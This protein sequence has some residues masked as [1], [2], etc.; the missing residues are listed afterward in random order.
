[1][2]NLQYVTIFCVK[3]HTF[4]STA[5]IFRGIRLD[6]P[7]HW[8]RLRDNLTSRFSRIES[9]INQNGINIKMKEKK[10][11]RAWQSGPLLSNQFFLGCDWNGLIT[12]NTGPF[13]GWFLAG[14][15]LSENKY[16]SIITGGQRK[17][18]R[19]KGAGK[20][21]KQKMQEKKKWNEENSP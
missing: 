6:K 15:L 21:W 13:S 18:Q 12:E 14:A 16:G 9:Q 8:L 5:E 11:S 7:I 20:R 10:N 2:I 4:Q 3:N 17:K 19:E 1:M